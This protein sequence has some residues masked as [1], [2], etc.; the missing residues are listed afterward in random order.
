MH[1]NFQQQKKTKM[2]YDSK[3]HK[4]WIGTMDKSLFVLD[5]HNKTFNKKFETHTEVII[6]LAI[7]NKLD[8]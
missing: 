1:S 8:E 6:S 2:L 4:I 3:E 7:L 5:V